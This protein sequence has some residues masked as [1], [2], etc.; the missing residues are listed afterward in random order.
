V[1]VVFR[2]AYTVYMNCGFV[3]LYIIVVS[4]IDVNLA[5]S[6]VYMIYGNSFVD[7]YLYLHSGVD[8]NCATSIIL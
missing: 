5:L 3:K 6:V 4:F 1:Y 8:S 2:V 7:V